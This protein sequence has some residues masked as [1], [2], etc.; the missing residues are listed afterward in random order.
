MIVLEQVRFTHQYRGFPGSSRSGRSKGNVVL[1]PVVQVRKSPT[2][3]RKV[4]VQVL[5]KGRTLVPIHESGVFRSSFR[6]PPAQLRRI[7]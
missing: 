7:L 1:R 4:S 5:T 6:Q 3:S 2:K